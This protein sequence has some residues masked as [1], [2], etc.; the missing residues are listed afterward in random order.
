MTEV[1]DEVAD[2]CRLVLPAVD[3]FSMANAYA[4]NVQVSPGARN[5]LIVEAALGYLLEYGLIE[6][7]DPDR[8]GYPRRLPDE[9]MPDVAGAVEASERMRAALMRGGVL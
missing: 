2:L 1:R 7:V 8:D 3:Q 5:R 9:V 6:A 4:L